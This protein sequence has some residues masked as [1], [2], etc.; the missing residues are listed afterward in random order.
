MI[1]TSKFVWGHIPKT[2]GDAL[3]K[4]FEIFKFK[5]TTGFYH[6]PNQWFEKHEPFKTR[7]DYELDGKMLVLN[8]RRL[9]NWIVSMEHQNIA[10][11]STNIKSI[12][13]TPNGEILPMAWPFTMPRSGEELC[14]STEGDNFL[15]AFMDNG[16][17]KIDYFLRMEHLQQDFLK[18]ISKFIIPSDIMIQ[19]VMG[20]DTYKSLD[21]NK[22]LSL[23]FTPNQIKTLYENNPIWAEVEARYYKNERIFG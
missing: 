3:F 15:K 5:L 11:R 20:T 19:Q 12:H 7:K 17:F 16:N 21:Y 1:I 18:F 2:G 10:N 6:H 8:I 13:A 9:P 4:Y 22:D 23:W 14:Y